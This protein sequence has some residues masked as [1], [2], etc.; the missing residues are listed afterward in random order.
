[1]NLI[2]EKRIVAIC[3]YQLYQRR[4]TKSY[5]IRRFDLEDSMKEILYFRKYCLYQEKIRV[6]GHQTIRALTW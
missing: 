1:M 5:I 4:M 3:H 6:N 2:S